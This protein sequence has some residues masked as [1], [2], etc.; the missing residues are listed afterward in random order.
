MRLFKKLILVAVLFI[1]VVANAST[2]CTG[3]ITEVVKWSNSDGM[4]ILIEGTDRYIR[5]VDETLISMALAA[6]MANKPVLVSWSPD[7]VTQCNN[8]WAH[9]RV[10]SGYF[11]VM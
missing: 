10:L 1:P 2:T 11:K 7:D 3:K 4:S 9:Y 5:L 6:H 8:G